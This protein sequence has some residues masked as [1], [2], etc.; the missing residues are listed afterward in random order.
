MCVECRSCPLRWRCLKR[1]NQ[2]GSITASP[3]Y[4]RTQTF[5]KARPA[6]REGEFPTEIGHSARKEAAGSLHQPYGQTSAAIGGCGPRARNPGAST[7]GG[8]RFHPCERAVGLPGKTPKPVIERSED[9]G[10]NAYP[11]RGKVQPL[12]ILCDSAVIANGITGHRAVRNPHHLHQSI[13][14]C[15]GQAPSTT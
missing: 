7:G 2:C 5:H 15:F 14:N 6:W 4:L 8:D 9:H 1:L 11:L 12:V 3:E 13:T 10:D